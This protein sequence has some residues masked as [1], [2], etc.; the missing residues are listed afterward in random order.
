MLV[1]AQMDNNTETF[2]GHD[3]V[4]RLYRTPQCYCHIYVGDERHVL[5]CRIGLKP[6]AL[7]CFLVDSSSLLD[8]PYLLRLFLIED[9]YKVNLYK[10]FFVLQGGDRLQVTVP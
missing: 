8:L 10:C 2:L 6:H 9:I 3:L 5:L 1:S 7:S 4:H